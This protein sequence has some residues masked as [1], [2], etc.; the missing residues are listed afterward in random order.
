MPTSYV[1][2]PPEPPSVEVEGR[3]ERF[4]VHRIYCVGRNYE[5]H[6]REMGRDPARE[7]PFFFTK[8][9]DAVV[10]N[11]ATIPYPSR[12]KNL[13]HEIELV[14]AIGKPGR[15][16]PAGGA[17]DHVFGYAVGNDLTRRD[18]QFEA[19]DKG[20]PWDTGK[21]F[22][23]SAAITAIRPVSAGGHVRRGRIWL[24]INGQV[25]QD[26][27]VADLIWGVPELIA[28]LSTLFELSTGDL[29]YTGTPAGVGPVVSGDRMEGGVAELPTL[30]TTIA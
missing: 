8:P 1:F 14:L 22:D 9:A 30:V 21:A 5:A 23:R 24:S 29:I 15:N 25:R 18:L 16:I 10:P 20:R 13:H 2:P 19:R 3:S 6:A 17:L 4:A 28:E 7:P 12:T 27:D 11:H 26:A